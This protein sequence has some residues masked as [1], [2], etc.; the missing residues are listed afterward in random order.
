M[1]LK[2]EIDWAVPFAPHAALRLYLS[3]RADALQVWTPRLPRALPSFDPAPDFNSTAIWERAYQLAGEQVRPFVASTPALAGAQ[4]YADTVGLHGT[5]R[6]GAATM[7]WTRAFE[8]FTL[9]AAGFNIY[10]IIVR[11]LPILVGLPL[12]L[13]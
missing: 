5:C 12:F 6:A 1:V 4:A 3:R 9:S 2:L 10:M 11:W 8:L 13:L 7:L